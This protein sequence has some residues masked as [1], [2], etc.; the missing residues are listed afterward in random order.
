MLKSAYT[1]A[2]SRR[3]IQVGD[4]L[5]KGEFRW[6]WTVVN[7]FGIEPR[8]LGFIASSTNQVILTEASALRLLEYIDALDLN[9]S[10]PRSINRTLFWNRSM[11]L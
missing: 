5:P 8:E 3:R 1:R 2:T 11:S 7:D 4:L 10:A 9:L 6:F